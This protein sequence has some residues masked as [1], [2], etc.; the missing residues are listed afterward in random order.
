MKDNEIQ[1]EI[2]RMGNKYRDHD[3]EFGCVCVR[4]REREESERE[5][6]CRNLTTLLFDHPEVVQP[7]FSSEEENLTPSDPGFLS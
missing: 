1:T 5:F 3:K 2:V 6:F 7:Q 4:E